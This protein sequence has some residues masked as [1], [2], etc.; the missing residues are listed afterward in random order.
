MSAFL[1][2]P[3]GGKN[4]VNEI[5]TVATKNRA[6]IDEDTM[7]DLKEAFTLFDTN[8]N[9]SIDYRELKAALRA[10][11]VK[12][13]TKQST[14]DIFKEVGKQE[15]DSLTADDFF[16]VMRNRMPK[17]DPR[18][19]AKKVFEY[20]NIDGTDKITFKTLKKVCESVGENFSDE[21]INQ[22]IAEAETTKGAGIDFKDFFRV[23]KKKSNDP[24]GEFDSDSD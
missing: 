6:L 23:M 21:E 8:H 9:G 16:K 17:K 14:L 12:N 5:R 2:K 19:E 20:F 24:L 13:V 7:E 4:Y 18:E 15:S 22:M 3:S 10:L 11:G 1:V